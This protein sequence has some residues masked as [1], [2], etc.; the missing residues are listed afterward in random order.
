MLTKDDFIR[1]ILGETPRTKTRAT[2]KDT[3]HVEGEVLKRRHG[4]PS[5]GG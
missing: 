4:P 5:P 3:G 2:K 1:H